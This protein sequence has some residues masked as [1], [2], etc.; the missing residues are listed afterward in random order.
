MLLFQLH[1]ECAGTTA[2]VE[3]VVPG[4]DIRSRD[5]FLPRPIE[6]HQVDERI[7]HGQKQIVPRR[8]KKVSLTHFC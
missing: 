4:F 2:D 5:K 3:N 8:G 7:V 6:S 1:N